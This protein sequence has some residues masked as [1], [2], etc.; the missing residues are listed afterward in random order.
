MLRE[1]KTAA[2]AS[3]GVRRMVNKLSECLWE[4]Q[5]VLEQDTLYSSQSSIGSCSSGYKPVQL[6]HRQIRQ[7][8][9][10]YSITVVAIETRL[11]YLFSKSCCYV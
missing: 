7:Y 6:V 4:V 3:Q 10:E 9:Q 2:G 8:S 1:R 11:E 5:E